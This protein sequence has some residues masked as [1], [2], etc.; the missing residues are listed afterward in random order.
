MPIIRPANPQKLVDHQGL[1][2]A[3]P[4]HGPIGP[5]PEGETKMTDTTAGPDHIEE[6]LI[7][8]R[9]EARHYAA[10]AL[11]AEKE[12]RYYPMVALLTAILGSAWIWGGT[13]AV[14]LFLAHALHL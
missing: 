1:I 7:L 10:Q 14:T 3:H 11:K 4:S 2:D 13:V 12:A 9:A 5:A 6:Q 8:M